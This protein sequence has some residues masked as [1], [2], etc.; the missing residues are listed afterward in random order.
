MWRAGQNLPGRGGH[1]PGALRKS[2]GTK[3]F[4]ADWADMLR[5]SARNAPKRRC[6]ARF[7]KY[8][9]STHIRYDTGADMSSAVLDPGRSRR[10]AWP[11]S[12]QENNTRCQ[13]ADTER[14]PNIKP[15]APL[16]RTASLASQVAA[17]WPF[18]LWGCQG[19]DGV[20]GSIPRSA[21]TFASRRSSSVAPVRSRANSDLGGSD[22]LQNA[23]TAC[24]ANS[25]V[26]E[27]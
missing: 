11:S 2:S 5:K 6:F 10:C 25:G 9:I 13:R 8:L 3:R 7:N 23:A 12:F 15:S 16:A 4:L 18:A 26:G 17:V 21:Q 22:G 20:S 19:I 14:D 27:A 1:R 24:F